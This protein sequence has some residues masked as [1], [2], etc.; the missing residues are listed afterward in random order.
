MM[1]IVN[2]VYRSNL[3]AMLILPRLDLPFNSLSELVETDIRTFVP[4]GS[5]VYK[6]VMESA[7]GT[8]LNR[9]AK[10]MDA[11]VNR[12][13]AI[14]N[15]VMG[16]TASLVEKDISLNTIGALY[17]E[18]KSCPLY[19]ASEKIFSH[20]SLSIAFPKGSKLKA[21]VDP[22]L[23]AL[24]ESGILDHLLN[25]QVRYTRRCLDTKT[26]AIGSD[27]RPLE[28]QDFYGLFC[29]YAGGII[30]ATISFIIEVSLSA[31]GRHPRTQ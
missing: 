3:K 12:S 16:K 6:A 19:V 1:L 21:K 5:F 7:P 25:Q 22:I 10:Q 13:L 8:T 27:R 26:E 20:S 15:V 17:N 31:R 4:A 24:K 28:L 30:L 2:T 14:S 11:H 9:F 18:T 23:T 29:I